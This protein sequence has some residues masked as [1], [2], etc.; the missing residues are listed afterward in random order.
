MND[1]LRFTYPFSALLMMV[2]PL[3]LGIFLA[4]KYRLTWKLFLYGAAA[5]VLAQLAHIPLNWVLT[6]FF[7]ALAPGGNALATAIVFGLTAA[8]TEE[9]ARYSVL[10]GKL[11]WARGWKEALM[12]GAGH[13]GLESILIGISLLASF[14]SLSALRANPDQLAQLPADQAALVQ[15]QL[16]AFWSASWYEAL[17][18]A[19]ERIF[20]LVIQISLA[21]MVM[22]VFLREDRR[23][24]WAAIA[25]HWLVNAVSVWSLSYFQNAFITELIVGVFALTGLMII[26][27]FRPAPSDTQ[28]DEPA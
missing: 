20:A 9:P 2:I 10:S 8:I 17:L 18:P 25:W 28:G 26:L 12:F 3:L 1:P 19:V 22:Q 21:V 23:W 24:L 27:Y 4:Q 16:Q 7:P 5:F 6:R 15:Q 11:K 13:G 14:I